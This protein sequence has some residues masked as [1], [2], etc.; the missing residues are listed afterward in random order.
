M[1]DKF[2]EIETI[3]SDL[4]AGDSLGEDADFLSREK[5]LLGDEFQTEQ[6][7]DV[8]AESDD[9]INDFKEQF[10]EVGDSEPAPAAPV[11]TYDDDEEFEGFGSAPT[12][13]TFDGESTHLREWKDRRDLEISEREKA[14]SKKKAEIV[15]EA[16]RTIDDFYDNYN[17]K[18]EQHSKE[19][20]K[21][22]EEFLANRDGFLKRGTLWDRVGEILTEVGDLPESEDRDKSKFKNLLGKLK[23]KDSVPGAGG[24]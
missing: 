9:D 6:D 16:Q 23:G 8:L 14:N 3:A 12:I 15:A 7:K 10:P 5:E 22:Q 2:P 17:N 24:Y 11:A 20:L 18:K 19:V 21:E 4:P 13:N 1:A